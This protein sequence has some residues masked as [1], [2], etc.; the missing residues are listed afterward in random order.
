MPLNAVFYFENV[1]TVVLQT[2][3]LSRVAL[4]LH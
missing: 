4:R 2:F 3:G 1:V